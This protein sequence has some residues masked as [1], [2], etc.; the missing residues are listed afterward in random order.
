MLACYW[1][2]NR[3]SL[4]QFNGTICEGV[5]APFHLEYSKSLYAQLQHFKWKFIKTWHDCLLPYADLHIITELKVGW[6]F[7]RGI[8]HFHLQK[9]IY[10]YIYIRLKIKPN[11]VI[12]RF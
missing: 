6:I 5:I 12:I 4:Q 1:M 3:I 10:I 2:K 11:S 7:Y 9:C 8:V